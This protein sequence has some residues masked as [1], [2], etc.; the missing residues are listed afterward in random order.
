M[1]AVDSGLS[2]SALGDP[3]AHQ[4]V[5]AA[6]LQLGNDDLL[7]NLVSS[8]PPGPKHELLFG[9]KNRGGGWAKRDRKPYESGYSHAHVVFENPSE[10]IAN[11]WDIMIRTGWAVPQPYMRDWA[12]TNPVAESGI[13]L[14]NT[15][16]EVGGLQFGSN[17]VYLAVLYGQ[18]DVLG[19]L[20]TMYTPADNQERHQ[21]LWTAAGRVDHGARH[22]EVCFQHGMENINWVGEN[23]H[24]EMAQGMDPIARAQMDAFGAT[25]ESTPLHVAARAGN[26]P[27]IELLVSR[28]ARSLLDGYGRNPVDSAKYYVKPDAVAV[29]TRLGL[30]ASDRR[31]EFVFGS[32]EYD[33]LM[34]RRM[35]ESSS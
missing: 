2:K 13:R 9:I 33:V 14:A 32:P 22:L 25:P 21:L 19:H 34:A 8:S 20:L 31:E 1:R 3:Y 10:N 30:V 23:H 16:I 26:V 6:A 7:T 27:A 4:V 29:L 11:V 18:P 24:E 15:L 5:V 35:E 28:G 17:E 12:A